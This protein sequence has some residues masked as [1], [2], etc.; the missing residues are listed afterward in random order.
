M[1]SAY[2]IGMGLLSALPGLAG[3]TPLALTVAPAVL[4]RVPARDLVVRRQAE[5]YLKERSRCNRR[6]RLRLGLL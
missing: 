5:I 1:T 3:S 6:L 2:S 4:S